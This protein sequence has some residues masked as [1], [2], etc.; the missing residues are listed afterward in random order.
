MSQMSK[1]LDEGAP[2]VVWVLLRVSPRENYCAQHMLCSRL[3]R[4][5]VKSGVCRF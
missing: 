5:K 3:Q 4:D 1:Q 2:N